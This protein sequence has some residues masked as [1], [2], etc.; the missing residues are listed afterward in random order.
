MEQCEKKIN[1]LQDDKQ[2]GQTWADIVD[3]DEKRT[4]EEVVRN[5]SRTEIVKKRN[6]KIGGQISSSFAR[7]PE[8]FSQMTGK[9]KI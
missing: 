6:G 3:S 4:A 5:Y 9:K 2:E 8:K 1:R 7:I